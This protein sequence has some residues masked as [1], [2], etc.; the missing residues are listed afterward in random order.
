MEV[1]SIFFIALFNCL[2]QNA[3][4]FLGKVLKSAKKPPFVA[5]PFIGFLVDPLPFIGIGH[6]YPLLANN[7]RRRCSYEFQVAT[8]LKDSPIP[9]YFTTGWLGYVSSLPMSAQVSLIPI[10]SII[11]KGPLKGGAIINLIKMHFQFFFALFQKKFRK[12]PPM[13]LYPRKGF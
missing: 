3:K 11:G 1:A 5:I 6:R 4:H 8:V 13:W 9:L 2:N 7:G 10:C 12:K